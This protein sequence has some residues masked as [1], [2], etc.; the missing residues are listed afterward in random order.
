MNISKIDRIAGFLHGFEWINHKSNNGYSFE[1]V[2]IRVC[3]SEQEAIEAYGN[4]FKIQPD[5]FEYA[6]NPFG[7]N[8]RK[9]LYKILEQ[10]LLEFQLDPFKSG[11]CLFDKNQEFS[12]SIDSFKRDM[13]NE[14]LDE[15][16]S[17]SRFSKGFG[18]E[19]D[20]GKSFYECAYND[21][22]LM[23]DEGCLYIHLGVSD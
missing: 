4:T 22:L 12:L 10:W 13:L 19:L 5:K 14:L 7:E 6:I 8:W 11:S 15:F 3:E 23:G 1:I 9:E 18:I 2:P 16:E 17:I 21:F 20:L